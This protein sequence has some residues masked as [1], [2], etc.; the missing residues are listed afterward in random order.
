ML[1]RYRENNEWFVLHDTDTYSVT[2]SAHHADVPG[3]RRPHSRIPVWKRSKRAGLVLDRGNMFRHLLW[4]HGMAGNRKNTSCSRGCRWKWGQYKEATAERLNGDEVTDRLVDFPLMNSY[5]WAWRDISGNE[6]VRKW[7]DTQT[8]DDEAFL[9]L[10][11]QLRYHGVSSVA[12][13]YRATALSNMTEILGMLTR[14]LDESPASKAGHCTELVAQIEQSIEKNRF[15]PALIWLPQNTKSFR[16]G[17]Q[18]NVV[19]WP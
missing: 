10:L 3:K 13:R 16:H 14:S 11:L 18:I 8:R 7:V 15:K 4:Q 9:K 19:R 12:G 1:E 5:V 17:Q 2:P 6:A